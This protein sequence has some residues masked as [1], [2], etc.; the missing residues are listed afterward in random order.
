MLYPIYGFAPCLVV[1]A[2]I[3]GKGFPGDEPTPDKI[4]MFGK[5][6]CWSKHFGNGLWVVFSIIGNGIV[7]GDKA[8]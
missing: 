7:I 2:S 1:P 6:Y 8:F 4:E 3:G 5:L